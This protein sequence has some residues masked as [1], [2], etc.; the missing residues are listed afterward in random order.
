MAHRQVHIGFRFIKQ[1]IHFIAQMRV[2]SLPPPFLMVKS[3]S[4]VSNDELRGKL[5]LTTRVLVLSRSSAGIIVLV[6]GG[7][8]LL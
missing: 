6:I 8:G 5:N 1:R 3:T 7:N 4:Y 2:S